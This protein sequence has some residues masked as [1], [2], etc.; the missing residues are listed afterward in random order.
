MNRTDGGVLPGGTPDGGEQGQL[1]LRELVDQAL[2]QCRTPEARESRPGGIATS[3][4]MGDVMTDALQALHEATGR[5]VP[6]REWLAGVLSVDADQLADEGPTALARL[7]DEIALDPVRQFIVPPMSAEDDAQD[8]ADAIEAAEQ[9]GE[10]PDDL[11]KE[12]GS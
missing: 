4:M 5:D 2:I 10:I 11:P 7:L 1:T 12:S 3:P 9:F 6:L 8:L